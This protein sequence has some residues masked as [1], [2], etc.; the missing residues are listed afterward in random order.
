MDA[1]QR[2]Q[3]VRPAGTRKG[4]RVILEFGICDSKSLNRLDTGK[5]E[6]YETEPCWM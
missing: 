4:S 3:A 6:L 1:C 2:G 5:V